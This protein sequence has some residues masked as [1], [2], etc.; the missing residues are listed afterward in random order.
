MLS[1]LIHR[2]AWRHLPKWL[3]WRMTIWRSWGRE[4]PQDEFDW[5]NYALLGVPP[6]RRQIT[7]RRW[8]GEKDADIARRFGIS[9]NEVIWHFTMTSGHIEAV[10]EAKHRREE[11]TKYLALVNRDYPAGRARMPKKPGRRHAGAR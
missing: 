6:L 7:L 2:L 5:Y 1:K 8:A 10:F 4:W 3:A 11:D 9:Q